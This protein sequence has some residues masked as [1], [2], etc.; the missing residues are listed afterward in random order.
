[1]S[2][3]L[4]YVKGVV[5]LFLHQNMIKVLDIV[6]LNVDSLNQKMVLVCKYYK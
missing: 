2:G 1:M 4:V 6:L 5:V 3:L